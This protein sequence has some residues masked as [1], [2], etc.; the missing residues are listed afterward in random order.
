VELEPSASFPYS[1]PEVIMRIFLVIMAVFT[2]ITITMVVVNRGSER[3]VTT[4]VLGLVATIGAL[5]A[6][7][8]YGADEPIHQAFSSAVIVHST[9]HLPFERAIGF[10]SIDSVDLMMARDEITK[11]PD[12]RDATDSQAST[13]YHHLLQRA[14]ISWLQLKYP[15][16]WEVEFLPHTLGENKGYLFASRAVPS[17]VYSPQELVLKL[18]GNKFGDSPGPFGSMSGL[19]LPPRTKL[20]IVFPRREAEGLTEI[21]S[22]LIGN[23]YCT[24]RIETRGAGGLRGV[25]SYG[26]VFG[27]S[28]IHDSGL[29]TNQYTIV[30]D[31]TFQRFLTGSPDMPRYKKWVANVADGLRTQFDEQEMWS[32]FRESYLLHKA[33]S[34]ESR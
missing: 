22:I 17:K 30:I 12:L 18:Q 2:A 32:R 29:W 10:S 19:A 15:F 11:H 27:L 34:S 33:F 3:I 20:E 4:F 1:K 13:L 8:Y 9:S 7:F 25:G 26:F 21:G 28:D 14:I 24:L 5:M 16:T 23:S 6:L 31:A